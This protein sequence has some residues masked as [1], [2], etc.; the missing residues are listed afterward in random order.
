[1][2]FVIIDSMELMDSPMRTDGR[3]K[4]FARL[5]GQLR[6]RARHLGVAI[7]AF[8]RPQLFEPHES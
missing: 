7:L 2:R 3:I 6:Q 1:V 5:V 8:R 4:G